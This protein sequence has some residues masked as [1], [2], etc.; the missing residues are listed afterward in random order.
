M[1]PGKLSRVERYGYATAMGK[2]H[3]TCISDSI[4]SHIF[5]KHIDSPVIFPVL[6]MFMMFVSPSLYL[7]LSLLF[8]LWKW[9]PRHVVLC[10]RMIQ[11]DS[12]QSCP[13]P[14]INFHICSAQILNSEIP[15]STISLSLVWRCIPV[16]SYL[17]RAFP[18]LSL[19]SV[20][21]APYGH[22]SAGN[23]WGILGLCARALTNALEVLPLMLPVMLC[24]V[25]C[26][27]FV[28]L[29]REGW[30]PGW[31]GLPVPVCWPGSEAN[32]CMDLPSL[33]SF[34]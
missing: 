11:R 7:W 23:L 9:W 32:V 5:S 34:S 33:T 28:G 22:L 15:F 10:H 30:G 29:K 1:A 16:I 12:D 14:L 21:S 3:W 18:G 19:S 20:S 25:V 2:G 8:S 24:P 17:C 6:M 27:G 31:L 4:V 26:S 13:G